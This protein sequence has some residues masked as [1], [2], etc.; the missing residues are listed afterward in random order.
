MYLF[1][2]VPKERFNGTEFANRLLD[3]GLALAPGEGFGE[4][5]DFIRISACQEE[6]KLMEG[7][8]TLNESLK[9]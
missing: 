7:M 1:A 9:E 6:K 3:H 8:N 2:R 5:R 4:Y